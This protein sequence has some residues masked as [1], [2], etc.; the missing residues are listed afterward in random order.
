MRLL[1][2]RPEQLALLGLLLASGCYLG[3]ARTTTPS[4][5]ARESGWQMIASVPEM[6][7]VAREDCGAAALAMVLQRWGYPVTDAEVVAAN[8]PAHQGGLP[9]AALRDFAR[10]K[11]LQA[12]LIQGQQGDLDREI[13]RRHPVLVG[14]MK[15]YLFRYYPHYEV[16][17]G[18]NRQRQNILTLDPAHGLRVNSL[19]GFA[20]EWARADQLALIVFPWAVTTVPSE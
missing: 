10:R 1:P 16:V 20:T 2:R 15:R 17:V 18:I 9:A 4:Q 3:S 13:R 12:F 14:V 6:H 19:D 5:L 11:G 8:S 7:Q